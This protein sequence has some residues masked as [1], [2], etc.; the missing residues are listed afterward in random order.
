MVDESCCVI[1]PTNS[2]YID[3]CKNFFAVVKRSWPDCPYRLVLSVTGE[4][5]KVDGVI[6][7]YNGPKASLVDCVVNASKIYDCDYYIV[8]LGD[9][10]MCGKV[11]TQSV[12]DILDD[13]KKNQIDFCCLHPEKTKKKIS[14]IGR[15][16]RHIHIRDR[17]CHCFGYILCS[18]R[19]LHEM[20][21]DSGIL[22]DL[23]YEVWYLNK[24]IESKTDYYYQHDAILTQNIFHIICGIKKGKWDRVAYHWI[25]KNYPEI[26]LA[27]RPKLS[28]LSQGMMILREKFLYLVPDYLRIQIKKILIYLTGIDLFDT[29]M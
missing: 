23:E 1:V 6:N 16:M 2:K 8:F 14:K 13:M 3:I 29:T 17:Y 22:T 7:L 27:V 12:K 15:Q 11:N 10:F 9:A 24:S 21:V 19:Y 25:K 26:Q 18:K 5:K 28:L 20:F 4:N